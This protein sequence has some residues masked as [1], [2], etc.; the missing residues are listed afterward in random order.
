MVGKTIIIKENNMIALYRVVFIPPTDV[1]WYKVSNEG[2][3]ELE[4][5]RY[6]TYYD[7]GVHYLEVYDTSTSDAGEY[8]CVAVNEIGEC[9]R[10]FVLNVRGKYYALKLFIQN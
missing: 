3:E 8:L 5:E 4:G 2:T 1:F 7:E 10:F 9:S 6:H